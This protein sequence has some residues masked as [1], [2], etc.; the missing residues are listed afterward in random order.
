MR[1]NPVSALPVL[2]SICSTYHDDYPSNYW[3]VM[4]S[5]LLQASRQAGAG[6]PEP[7]FGGGPTVEPTPTQSGRVERSQG[8]EAQNFFWGPSLV[9]GR[10]EKVSGPNLILLVV[11]PVRISFCWR[12]H[13]PPAQSR[14][15]KL[16]RGPKHLSA[17]PIFKFWTRYATLAVLSPVS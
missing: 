13:P 11:P 14:Q 5:R 12:N 10:S 7:V 4:S 2:S 1:H 16:Q 3:L 9:T 17:G 8:K 15:V 6:G